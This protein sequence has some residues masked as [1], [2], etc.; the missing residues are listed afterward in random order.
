MKVTEMKM[1]F[2]ILNFLLLIPLLLALGIAT[3]QA[4]AGDCMKLC[5]DRFWFRD[6]TLADVKAEIA[7]GADIY[8]DIAGY[9]PLHYAAYRSTPEIV[10]YLA[11]KGVNLETRTGYNKSAPGGTTPLHYAITGWDV[12]KVKILTKAGANVNTQ[13]G[14]GET[15]L[16]G[17]MKG[18]QFDVIDHLLD[19]GADASIKD[20][21]GKTPFDYA[22]GNPEWITNIA[23]YKRLKAASG[24]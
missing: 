8:D 20:R 14:R 7:K 13:D 5:D 24:E 18:K 1:T 2:P 17:A 6:P 9:T 4:S 16:H 10:Q 21:K 19:A 11:D 3:K 12:A 23:L 22:K 15:P